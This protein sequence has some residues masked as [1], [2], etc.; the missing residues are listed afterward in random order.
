MEAK[1]LQDQAL[2]SLSGLEDNAKYA[3]YEQKK[4]ELLINMQNQTAKLQDTIVQI[5]TIYN[6]VG[7]AV[8]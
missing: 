7:S 4:T 5:T 1:K 6:I 3:E 8:G 2:Q